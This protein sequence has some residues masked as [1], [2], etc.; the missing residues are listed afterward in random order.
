MIRYTGNAYAYSR[1]K[2]EVE[3]CNASE[4]SRRESELAEATNA[5]LDRRRIAEAETEQLRVDLQLARNEC[6]R[7]RG[8]LQSIGQIIERPEVPST[9][10]ADLRPFVKSR[11]PE[12]L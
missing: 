8:L 11:F 9:V 2:A 5:E 3:R 7:L 12:A 6:A 1:F 4:R 10:A